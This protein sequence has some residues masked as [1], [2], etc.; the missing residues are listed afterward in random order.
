MPKNKGK[1]I[2]GAANKDHY[3][4]QVDFVQ[5]SNAEDIDL[6][7]PVIPSDTRPKLR[8]GI[9]HGDINGVGYEVI[10]KALAHDDISQLMIPIIFGYHSLAKKCI[11]TF[12]IESV[13]LNKIFN[14]SDVEEGVV[15]I[16][17]IDNSEPTLTP[18]IP[19][20]LSGQLSVK[21][22]DMAITALKNGE[23][24]VLVTAP[25]CKEVVQNDTFHFPGH[26]EYLEDKD[27][28]Y[29]KALM[30][31]CTETLR[32]VPATIHTPLGKVQQNI[33]A[34]TIEDVL[35]R[36]DESLKKDFGVR[37]PR[38]AVLSL[39]P[40]AGDGGLLGTDENEVIIPAIKS[41]SEKGL[42]VFGP[43]AADGFFGKGLY[44]KFDGVVSMYHD[45]GL[46]PFKVLANDRGV[47][48]TAGLSFVRTSPDHG[49]AFD[50][51]WKGEADPSSMREAIY[52]AIDIFR[53]R[54]IDDEIHSN[55]LKKYTH[56]KPD[57][58]ERHEKGDGMAKQQDKS[59]KANPGTEDIKESS[60][61]ETQTSTPESE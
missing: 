32:V 24:D 52:R 42:L 23:I 19:S 30:I 43:F 45:Q 44:S 14:L 33:S 13:H 41:A 20:S 16:I 4:K 9:T 21:A 11:D 51:A 53:A 28:P 34:D 6:Q 15:N 48:F 2:D 40:H 1:N 38:I 3:N 47:N 27:K 26:T 18:G 22:L 37:R 46:I 57:R 36:F 39:N 61:T 58:E 55:I 8:V 5:N 10:L 50:I 59:A 35:M 29:G 56:T 12:G 49:T 31:L 17:D 7:E 54:N 60:V 25:I